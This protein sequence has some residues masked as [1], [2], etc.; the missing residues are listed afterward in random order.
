MQEYGNMLIEVS[1]F[2]FII[3]IISYAMFFSYAIL[4]AMYYVN[5]TLEENRDKLRTLM[6]VWVI[7]FGVHLG[8]MVEW[9]N[10]PI[11]H[12]LTTSVKWGIMAIV[13]TIVA[14]TVLN[15]F[16]NRVS[17]AMVDEGEY[18]ETEDWTESLITVV[19]VHI[20]L[21]T[22]YSVMNILMKALF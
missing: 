13:S 17:E 1:T 19:G 14:T 7:L 18:Y 4:R 16:R 2:I 9:A 15:Y 11:A 8:G 6:V 12:F 20:V 3:G 10:I 5:G 21:I 22:V